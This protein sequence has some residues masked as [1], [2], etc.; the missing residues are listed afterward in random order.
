MIVE[1]SYWKEDIQRIADRLQKRSKQKRWPERSFYL[2]EKD[3]FIAFYGIRKL[4]EAKKL[5]QATEKM[6]IQLYTYPT[7]GYGVTRLN[8]HNIDRLFDL[9]KP[10]KQTRELK[11]ICNQII[12]SYVFTPALTEDNGLA[13]IMFSSERERNQSL[14]FMETDHLIK[15]LKQSHQIT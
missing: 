12:H 7:T 2:V 13:G 11:F 4:I 3:V 6:S 8:S 15:A 10:Q 9:E 14:Y 5:T 1:S